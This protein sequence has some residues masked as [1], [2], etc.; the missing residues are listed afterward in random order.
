M[1]LSF[2]KLRLCDSDLILVDDIDGGGRDRDWKSVARELLHRRRG[3]GADRLAVVA[4]AERDIWL[5]VFRPDGESDAAADAALCAARYLLDSGRSASDR[6]RMRLSE[7][8]GRSLEVDVLDSASLGIALGPPRR[9]AASGG[10]GEALSFAETGAQATSIETSGQRFLVLPL[11][12]GIPGAEGVAVFTDEG[13]SRARA[14]I[15]APKRPQ[16][17]LPL[18]VNVV[19]RGELR[20]V[21]SHAR[22]GLDSCAAAG[23][24][25]AA[26]A[27]VGYSDREAIV[28]MREGAL[29][30][31]WG[32]TG[33]LYAAGRPEYV[34]R[35]EYHLIE[36]GL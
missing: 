6:V 12:T 17:P 18:P 26:S 21:L 5:R 2:Y 7:A 32:P 28:R 33:S 23:L 34:Y 20:I 13:A 9:V 22:G 27:A 1:E 15:A 8:D 35:G 30:L 14:R 24:A 10:E 31:E 16:A 19:S 29:W 25:L 36:E 11:R 3:A 4:R